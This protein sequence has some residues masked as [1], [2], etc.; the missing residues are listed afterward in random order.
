MNSDGTWHEWH[1]VSKE[2]YIEDQILQIGQPIKCKIIVTP[3]A[4]CIFTIELS[5]IGTPHAYDLLEGTYDAAKPGTGFMVFENQDQIDDQKQVFKDYNIPL[6]H[7]P[8]YLLINEPLEYTWV[9]QPNANW[10]CEGCS[11]APLNCD[12]VA[13]NFKKGENVIIG[14]SF[15]VP[16][17]RGYWTGPTYHPSNAANTKNNPQESTSTPGFDLFIL[18]ISLVTFLIILRQ[19]CRNR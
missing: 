8:Q 6:Y 19:T 11:G 17:I 16:I 3:H 5:E 14:V 2:G 12:F 1:N 4:R 10:S 9:L 7:Q 18:I 15:A 13:Q